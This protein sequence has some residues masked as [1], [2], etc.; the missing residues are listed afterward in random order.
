MNYFYLRRKELKLEMIGKILPHTS[1]TLK[2]S[3]NVEILDGWRGIAI[4]FVLLSHFFPFLKIIDLGRLGVDIFFVLSGLLMSN[5]LF[6]KRVPLGTFYKKRISR[7]FPV[8]FIYVT[9]VYLYGYVVLNSPET[10]NYFHTLF[11]LRSYIPISPD[12]LHTG[13]PIGHIWS[14]NIEEHCYVVLSIISLFYV[15]RG[16]EYL[17]LF[18]LGIA[19]FAAK[20]IYV[21][22]ANSIGFNYDI[23]SE[24]VASFIF[25]S[26]GYFLI[27]SKFDAL[28][29]SFM[30][31]ITFALAAYCY[32]DNVPWYAEAFFPP[33]LLAFTV[34]HL[35]KTPHF[36]QQLLNNHYLKRVGILSFSLYLW[37]QPFYFTFVKFGGYSQYIGF[38]VLPVAFLVGV[39]SFKYIEQPLRVWINEH[40][41]KV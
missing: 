35:E 6:L 21:K 28:V 32:S 29:P 31:V 3:G 25:F 40:W 17:P 30:P 34:N 2:I 20:L 41:A 5:I 26:A 33:I 11:F 15:F 38:I 24:V 18:C 16:R 39:I 23:R 1:N 22:N 9:V 19:T 8:F 27:K 14:L 13:L 7:V 12:I 10:T 37:Q 36:F 4:I